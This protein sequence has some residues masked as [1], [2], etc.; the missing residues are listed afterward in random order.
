M[1][2]D[3][4]DLITVKGHITSYCS[5]Y[6][7]TSVYED[8]SG[9]KYGPDLSVLGCSFYGS[10]EAAQEAKKLFENAVLPPGIKKVTY[11]INKTLVE[12]KI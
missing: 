3:L 11:T 12:I 9:R 10:L 7:L 6:Y 5:I 2:K 1:I 4:Q 8:E